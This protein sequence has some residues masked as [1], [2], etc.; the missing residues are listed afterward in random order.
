MYEV[1]QLAAA[2]RDTGQSVRHCPQR[3]TCW[4]EANKGLSAIV[5]PAQDGAPLPR[6]SH[7]WPRALLVRRSLQRASLPLCG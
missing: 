3:R 4:R 7:H 2:H 6:P 5:R 1:C